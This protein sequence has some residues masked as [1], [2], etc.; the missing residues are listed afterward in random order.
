VSLDST[1]VDRSLFDD[2]THAITH[3]EEIGR[4]RP[5][6]DNDAFFASRLYAALAAGELEVEVTRRGAAGFSEA[7][8]LRLPPVFWRVAAFRI[9][10]DPPQFSEQIANEGRWADRW[11]DFADPIV[12]AAPAAEQRPS[13]RPGSEPGPNPKSK[14]EGPETELATATA[15]KYGTKTKRL[16]TALRANR[17]RLEAMETQSERADFLAQKVNCSKSHAKQFLQREWDWT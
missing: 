12:R 5:R 13:R 6:K 7:L 9:L 4:D 10:R 1:F 2:I 15:A 3:W 14:D 11:V 8:T 17:S 16:K